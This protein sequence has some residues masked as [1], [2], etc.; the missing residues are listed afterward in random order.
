MA[1]KPDWFQ[2][3]ITLSPNTHVIVLDDDES[4]HSVWQTLFLENI[5][6]KSVKLDHFYEPST[7]ITY[8]NTSRSEHDLFLVDYE[9]INSRET[10]LDLIEQLNLK[11]QS[12]LVTSRYEEPEIRERIKN[13]GIKLIPKSFAPYIPISMKPNS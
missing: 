7:F 12:I 10:G 9:L 11:K 4:I 2:S 5:K 1:K 13:L 8:C 6:N 3:S